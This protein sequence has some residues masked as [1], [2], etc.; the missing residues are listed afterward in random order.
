ML[1]DCVCHDWI[2]EGQNVIYFIKDEGIW[3]ISFW[4]SV[5]ES[6]WSDSH[7][8]VH[9]LVF[10]D[11]HKAHVGSIHWWE[12]CHIPLLGIEQAFLLLSDGH[13]L[14]S[15]HINTHG[16]TMA[17]RE[18]D[19]QYGFGVLPSASETFPCL[20]CDKVFSGPGARTNH[21]R[22]IHQ[23]VKFIC[24]CGKVYVYQSSLLNHK[25]TCFMCVAPPPSWRNLSLEYEE[26]CVLQ[27]C[28]VTRNHLLDSTLLRYRL[29]V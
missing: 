26:V 17:E 3:K 18:S 12:C 11:L 16:N 23:K 28:V 27:W 15:S 5:T 7:S 9:V 21:V 10:C 25:K 19:W 29:D 2:S 13:G 22:S 4:R 14:S 20:Y 6:L 24:V 8:V 1:T